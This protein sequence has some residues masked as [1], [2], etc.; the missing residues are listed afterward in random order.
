MRRLALVLALAL[1]GAAAALS[2]CED[3]SLYKAGASTFQNDVLDGGA[4][5][6][7]G[8]ASSDAAP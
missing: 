8:G 2:A 5:G 6:A 4:A 3:D 1:V 7:G